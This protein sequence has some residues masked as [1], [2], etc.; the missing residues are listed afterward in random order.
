MYGILREIARPRV[1]ENEPATSSST[2]LVFERYTQCLGSLWLI[3]QWHERHPLLNIRSDLRV[4]MEQVLRTS[5]LV[6]STLF[7]VRWLSFR[8]WHGYLKFVK[9]IEH[10]ML[11][12]R[13]NA[14]ATQPYAQELPKQRNF[15]YNL[16][17]HPIYR[18]GR[19][20]KRA[21]DRAHDSLPAW[22][23][24]TARPTSN[25]KKCLMK[26]PRPG[27][28]YISRGQARKSLNR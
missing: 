15:K 2:W 4:M 6:L 19:I 25:A 10:P 22:P 11:T 12:S 1:N 5:R 23:P 20:L 16:V 18:A 8:V 9:C 21:I 28:L 3:E 7:I 26:R 24:R 17:T 13:T 14:T 27:A